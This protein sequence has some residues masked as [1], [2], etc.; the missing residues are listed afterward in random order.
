M[1]SAHVPATARGGHIQND[2]QAS[3]ATLLS[4]DD[5]TEANSIYLGHQPDH[6]VPCLIT[7]SSIE[8]H[9][10]IMGATGSGKTARVVAPILSQLIRGARR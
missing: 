2:W 8:G 3:V 6:D 5:S 10:L 9:V 7:K 1:S 4:S